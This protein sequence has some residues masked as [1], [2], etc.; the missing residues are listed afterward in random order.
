[1]FHIIQNTAIEYNN[2]IYPL[3]TNKSYKISRGHYKLFQ[4]V[5]TKSDTY[6]H[7]TH[8]NDG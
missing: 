6:R 1:M 3:D 5:F 4:P 2:T 7:E 8:D